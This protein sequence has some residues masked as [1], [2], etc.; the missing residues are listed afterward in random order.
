MTAMP[1]TQT[2]TAAEFLAVPEDPFGRRWILVE[3][4]LILNQPT[5]DHQVLAV[6]LAH[7]LMTW[8]EAGPDRGLVSNPLDVMLDDRNVYA[9][10]VIWYSKERAPAPGT[11][12]PYPMPDLA[13]EVRSPTTWRY[14]IGAKKA[15]YERTGL[16]ELWLADTAAAEILIFRRSAPG[17]RTFDVSLQLTRG[18]VL[19]SPLLA[20]LALPL[21]R[22]FG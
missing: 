7:E 10:D 6:R 14:D 13:V 17:A 21:D 9:P 20:G 5:L 16:R 19:E 1:A 8:I 4:E 11:R 2:M 3:G 18:D 12:A 22:L 15:G